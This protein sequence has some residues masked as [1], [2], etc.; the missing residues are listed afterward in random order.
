MTSITDMD[1][2]D[3]VFVGDGYHFVGVF[4]RQNASYPLTD[5]SLM[6]TD[7]VAFT[8]ASFDLVNDIWDLTS[9]GAYIMVNTNSSEGNAFTAI[10]E[11][12]IGTGMFDALDVDLWLY[13][14][15]NSTA[16]DGYEIVEADYFN[17]YNNGGMEEYEYSGDGSGDDGGGF[18]VLGEG[19]FGLAASNSSLPEGSWA[20]ANITWRKLQ[21]VGFLVHIWQN[22]QYDAINNYWNCPS[23]H[24]ETATVEYGI[25]YWYNESWMTGWS[26]VLEVIDG[27][28][29]TFGWGGDEAWVQINATWYNGDVA[30]D[31]DTFFA[32]YEAIEPTDSSTQFALRVDL[33]IGLEEGSSKVAGR[34]RPE[35]FGMNE[36]GWGPWANWRPIAGLEDEAVFFDDLLD[37]D[38]DTISAGQLELFISWAN[39]TK[40]FPDAGAPDCDSHLWALIDYEGPYWRTLFITD[41]M[42]GISSPLVPD[43]ITPGDVSMGFFANLITAMVDGITKPIVNALGGGL[44]ATYF[45]TAGVI[46]SAFLF[47]GI[48]DFMASISAMILAYG[49]FFAMSMA[50]LILIVVQMF[51][52]I[53]SVASFIITWLTRMISFLIQLGTI[54]TAILNGTQTGIGSLIDIWEMF[55]VN[56]WIDFIPIAIFISWVNAIDSRARKMGGGW[57]SIFIG[58][59]QMASWVI[60]F[61]VDWMSRIV[62]FVIDRVFGIMN[63]IALKMGF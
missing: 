42:I 24:A 15:D 40:V 60:S 14:E 38:G 29:G 49:A 48:P 51:R 22:T 3:W 43:A 45:F 25:D 6:F 11:L 54:V 27:A 31:W 58:D 20:Y 23:E 12:Y 53:T 61:M 8:I 19:V 37:Q 34:V 2:T 50:N 5:V 26:V 17:I 10:W 21:H 28:A 30:I 46:D 59:L 16:S 56:E 36:T 4:V 41:P 63:A 35:Y 62:S 47:F 55:Q 9:N 18:S 33:W 39:L 7:G 57:M 44:T 1:C 13:C 52:I 32:F